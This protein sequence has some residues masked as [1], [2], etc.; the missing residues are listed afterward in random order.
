MCVGLS[1]RIMAKVSHTTGC[2]NPAKWLCLH[3]DNEYLVRGYRYLAPPS[4]GKML[5]ICRQPSGSWRTCIISIFSIHNETGEVHEKWSWYVCLLTLAAPVNI[6]TH[7]AG[8]LMFVLSPA[9]AFNYLDGSQPNRPV[10]EVVSMTLYSGGAA[11]CFLLS[12]LWRWSRHRNVG[13]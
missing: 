4:N 6:W 7:L 10:M 13:F 2:D 12:A 11:I 5:T 1:Y 8:F 9:Y 3:R